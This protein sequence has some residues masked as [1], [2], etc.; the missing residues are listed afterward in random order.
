MPAPNPTATTPQTRRP[1]SWVGL[2]L[3]LVAFTMVPAIIDVIVVHGSGEYLFPDQSAVTKLVLVKAIAVII[4]VAP[5]T[6]LRWWPVV[7]HEDLRTRPW[8]WVVPVMLL[9][10][11]VATVD[12]SRLAA[13]GLPLALTLLLAALLIG[14]S[15]EFM[16]RG[17]LLTFL[18]D[19][20]REWIAALV[21]ALLFGAFHFLAGPIQ[22][23][24]SAIMGY[25][26]Y[27][28]RRV[29]GGIWVPIVMHAAWDYSVFTGYT[30]AHPAVDPDTSL[31]LFLLSVV[32]FIALLV[33][34]RAA[35][36]RKAPDVPA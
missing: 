9:V 1:L 22:V 26:L 31:I 30:T 32:A 3:L 16:F 5:I 12:Y 2:V 4:V 13:A 14:V 23:L 18:R 7:L 17:V 36:P 8:V 15:E 35:E 20:Y 19:R 21:S 34:H 25:L 10:A 28:T 6:A 11:S 27:Y 33:G 24:S 29:S